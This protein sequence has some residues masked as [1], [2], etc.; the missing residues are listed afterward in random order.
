[1]PSCV[2]AFQVRIGSCLCI[3]VL[4]ADCTH[5]RNPAWVSVTLRCSQIRRDTERRQ[6]RS[7]RRDLWLRQGQG[8]V[9]RSQKGA[10]HVSSSPLSLLQPPH[11]SLL[12][13]LTPSPDPPVRPA[14]PVPELLCWQLT[15]LLVPSPGPA[16]AC[17]CSSSISQPSGDPDP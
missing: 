4:G 7:K 1:M 17:A 12:G 9:S 14:A 16:L 11:S 8:H 5:Q 10:G 3:S 13:R 2:S 6:P 15:A